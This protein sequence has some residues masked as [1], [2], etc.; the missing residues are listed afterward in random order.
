MSNAFLGIPKL[1]WTHEKNPSCDNRRARGRRLHQGGQVAG[2]QRSV[3]VADSPDGLG[4]AHRADTGA[5]TRGCATGNRNVVRI[6]FAHHY[7]ALE[8]LDVDAAFRIVRNQQLIR[9]YVIRHFVGLDSINV[10]RN[11]DS[12]EHEA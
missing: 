2:R 8:R 9:R 6:A 4:L 12:E 1:H 7:A 11:H 5:G 3:R 10:V